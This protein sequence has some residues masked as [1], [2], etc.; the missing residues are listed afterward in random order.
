LVNINPDFWCC[1]GVC[2]EGLFI[3]I[4]LQLILYI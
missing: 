2:F 4:K 1:N 3:P